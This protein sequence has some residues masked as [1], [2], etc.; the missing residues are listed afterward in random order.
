MGPTRQRYVPTIGT[1]VQIRSNINKN[2][3]K[4]NNNGTT[5]PT[6]QWQIPMSVE[7]QSR[8]LWP[9]APPN[10]EAAP[11]SDPQ[12]HYVFQPKKLVAAVAYGGEAQDLE[13]GSIRKQ[14]YER[15]LKDGLYTPKLDDNGRPIFFF[16][17]GTT[18]ACYTRNGGLGMCVYEW[19]PSWAK[20]N[21]VGLELEIPR[22]INF[23]VPPPAT[24]IKQKDSEL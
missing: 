16:S 20:A 14:L 2:A 19:R 9:L 23:L 7:F 3:N 12:C 4:N 22:E 18:K 13:I 15:V 24:A 21:Q 8:L 11:N 5:L 6:L 17:Y 10:D 1:T